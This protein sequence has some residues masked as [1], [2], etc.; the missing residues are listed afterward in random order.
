MPNSN[1]AEA[2][3][4]RKRSRRW[5][6]KH[7]NYSVSV[8]GLYDIWNPGVSG[9]Q[10]INGYRTTTQALQKL[11]KEA[12]SEG[13]RVRPL[14]SAWSISQ[15]AA[16]DGWLINT[17][18]LNWVFRVSD[19][20]ISNEYEGDRSNLLFVQCGVSIGELNRYLAERGKSLKTSG[21]SNGQTIA[22]AL[23]TG[24]HGSAMN[25]GAIQD[26]V[27][28]IHLITGPDKHL[29][30]ERESCPVTKNHFTERLGADV[31]R[32][33]DTFNAAL[34]SFG[35]FGIIH[36]VMIETEDIYL[37]ESSRL[38]IP[39][40]DNLKQAFSTLDFSK[41]ALPR[42][43]EAPY[44]FEIVINP[45]ANDGNAF[46]TV[47]YKDPYREGYKRRERSGGRFQPGDDFLS[48]IGTLLDVLPDAIPGA[49]NT[50]LSS[51]YREYAGRV[52]TLGEIFSSTSIRGKSTGAAMGVPLEEAGR[53]VEA[54]LKV[55]NSNRSFPGVIALRYVRKSQA[56]L[57]FTKYNMTCVIDLDAVDNRVSR[58]FF[59][60]VWKEFEDQKIPY[61]IHWGKANELTPEQL[62]KMYGDDL[63]TWL[64]ERR[65]LL[66]DVACK[67][68][69]NPFTDRCGLS[70]GQ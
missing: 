59:R 33:D 35:S 41:I 62:K 20:N 26:F 48:V 18:P 51:Q 56:L 8:A 25:V 55:H 13:V 24:T 4:V 3:I 27:V 52:G 70:T 6:N 47:M 57:A 49:V 58:Q 63:Q 32:N 50:L 30:L 39:F 61:T 43:Q 37:L 12:I 40:N 53:A 5:S 28:G 9:N 17:K 45:H 67:T 66:G 23:S 21:A 38:K 31:I 7:E 60:K 15:V 22:G 10:L 68:F 16:T 19:Q 69:S 34:V 14:G 29:W 46:T 2:R 11:T 54:I 64:S 44:H 65:K 36:G 42:E 1:T